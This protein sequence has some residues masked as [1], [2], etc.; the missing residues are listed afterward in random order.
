MNTPTKN[1]SRLTAL[2]AV[3]LLALTG[4]VVIPPQPAVAPVPTSAIDPV[5]AV[6]PAGPVDAV[7]ASPIQ[8]SALAP[9]TVAWSADAL[10][11]S[12]PV[13]V[14]DVAPPVGE[15]LGV[16]VGRVRDRQVRVRRAEVP[17][18]AVDEDGHQEVREQQVG[19][20]PAHAP[21]R[22][23]DEVAPA[24]GVQGPPQQPLGLR[25]AA[26]DAAHPETRR[27][28]R[29]ELVGARLPGERRRRHPMTLRCRVTR[30]G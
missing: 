21:H 2:V 6:D 28:V 14:G 29:V 8:E 4:C 10:L 5:P 13:V 25:V 17:E 3:S 30:R 22:P 18:A 27:R 20:A 19:P 15:Q 7:P 23:V 9:A 24:A 26:A 16:P 1:L 12:A 11:V